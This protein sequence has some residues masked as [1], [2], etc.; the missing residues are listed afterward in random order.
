MTTLAQL[1]NA[2]Q[3]HVLHG[4][5][6]AAAVIHESPQVPATTRLGVYA[7]AYRLRLIEALESNYPITVKALAQFHGEH[8]F[9]RLAQEYL[10]IYPSQ[11]FSIRWF[12][13]RLTEFAQQFPDYCE[14]KWLTELTAWEWRIATAFDAEDAPILTI[15]DL[16]SVAPANWPALR[17]IAQPSVQRIA[18][19]T[20]VVALVKAAN[21]DLPLPSPT[22]LTAKIEWLIWRLD[23]G[24]QF[25]SLEESEATALDAVV[26]G[27]T[28]GEICELLAG[29]FDAADVPLQAA[30]LLKRWT[31]DQ[32]MVRVRSDEL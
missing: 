23:L 6:T 1:Q 28:F 12:G 29:Y 11:H 22:A 24:V 8:A 14:L 5:V 20:N 21:E 7:D 18:L 26:A 3:S 4:D 27:A 13:H 31:A 10:A 30:T 25:R 16:S 15:D 9:A 2:L 32:C 17:F 19:T